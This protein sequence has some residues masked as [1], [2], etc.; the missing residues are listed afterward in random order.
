M[1]ARRGV[2][3]KYI[4]RSRYRYFRGRGSQ[5]IQPTY[6]SR[7]N[8]QAKQCTY[9]LGSPRAVGPARVEAIQNLH[10]A[11]IIHLRLEDRPRFLWVDAL[12]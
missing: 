7:L 8:R 5:L 3:F 1:N 2:V 11:L 12:W 10:S 4:G 9:R 6:V